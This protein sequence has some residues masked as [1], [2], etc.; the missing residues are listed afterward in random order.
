MEQQ[1]EV[2]MIQLFQPDLIFQ[3]PPSSRRYQ[4][5]QYTQNPEF[6]KCTIFMLRFFSG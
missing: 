6:G 3:L 2:I 4:W 1:P 5:K